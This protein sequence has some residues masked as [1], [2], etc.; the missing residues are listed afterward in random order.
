M[1]GWIL[2]ELHFIRP[3][4]PY[5]RQEF[6]HPA[7]VEVGSACAALLPGKIHCTCGWMHYLLACGLVCATKGVWYI[8]AL[9]LAGFAQPRRRSILERDGT[10]HPTYS[11]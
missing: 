2:E 6:A 5:E 8:I 3:R 9:R 11:D 4:I 10:F 1:D 7:R